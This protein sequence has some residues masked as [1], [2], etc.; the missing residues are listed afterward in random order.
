[1]CSVAVIEVSTPYVIV[2]VITKA[3]IVYGSGFGKQCK[4][5]RE[6]PNDKLRYLRLFKN[7]FQY[8]LPFFE[9]AESDCVGLL[10]G[11]A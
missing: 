5:S 1:M 11:L 9:F 7:G 3:C 2:F 4:A 8:E 10:L 6:S